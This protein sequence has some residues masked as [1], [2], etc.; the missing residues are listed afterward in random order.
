M[1][2]ALR[3]ESRPKGAPGSWAENGTVKSA[4]RVLRILEFFDNIRRP[5]TATEIARH[6]AF[7]ASS[8]SQLLRSMTN[9]GY[10]VI[11]RN[12]RE[13]SPSMRVSLLG[14][15]WNRDYVSEGPIL[16]MMRS[17]NARTG[18]AIFL[19]VQSNCDAQYIHAYQSPLPGRPHLALGTRRPLSQCGAGIALLSALPDADVAKIVLRNNAESTS[20]RPVSSVKGVLAMTAQARTD[21]F[22]CFYDSILSGGVLASALCPD[23][24]TPV[25]VC[26]GDYLNSMTQNCDELK[27]AF[28]D[29]LEEYHAVEPIPGATK[30]QT[31]AP[32]TSEQESV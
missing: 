16:N 29:A 20:D 4:A 14:N 17:L 12:S 1:A 15:G 27:A 2:N 9:T 30:R 25:A 3:K 28:L 13:Y 32:A 5:A 8:T 22:V 21:G 7:P 6:F 10:L 26:M 11:D 19:A 23:G 24:G 31:G 18:R